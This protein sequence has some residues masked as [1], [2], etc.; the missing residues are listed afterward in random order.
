MRNTSNLCCIDPHLARA[1][2]ANSWAE[3]SDSVLLSGFKGQLPEFYEP[4]T[5][6]L[7]LGSISIRGP[8][9]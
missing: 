3:R 4:S 9:V 8:I 5:L 6:W 1:A 7:Y 2:E